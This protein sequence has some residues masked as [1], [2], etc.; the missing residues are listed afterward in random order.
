MQWPMLI[1]TQY[2]KKPALVFF[3]SN[4][5]RNTLIRDLTENGKGEGPVVVEN[6]SEKFS[7]DKRYIESMVYPASVLNK[8][9]VDQTMMEL[10]MVYEI[11]ANTI[12]KIE[13]P[14]V[15]KKRAANMFRKIKP[16]QAQVGNEGWL[17]IQQ[18]EWKFAIVRNNKVLREVFV[19]EMEGE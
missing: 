13:L 10:V 17:K 11:D 12:T 9:E 14:I 16:L 7:T 1:Q 6:E 8:K 18:D 5:K 2:T 3:D 19:R 15:G 4:Q